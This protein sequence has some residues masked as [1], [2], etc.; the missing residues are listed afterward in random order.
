MRIRFLLPVLLGSLFGVTL[1][2]QPLSNQVLQLLTRVNTWTATNTFLDLRLTTGV[3]SD[4][5]LRFYVDNS[6]NLYF[7][8]VL[9]AG[10]GSGVTPHNVLSTTHPDTLTGTVVR[11]DVIV[12]NATPK[13]A[14]LAKG[15]AGQFLRSDGTDVSW[16]V[17][18]SALTN[19]N[20]AALTGTLGAASGVNLTNLNASN[21]ASGT[22]PLARLSGITNTQIDA[23][24]AI[25]YAKLNLTGAVLNADIAAAA[26]IPYSKLTLTNSL[27][28]AD[29][30]NATLTFGK[31][32]ANGCTNGQVPQYNGAAWVCG[33]LGAGTGTVTSV[34]LALPA[35]FSVSG[36]PVTTSGTLT[37]TLAT[38]TANTVFAGPTTGAAATP[39][40]RA[41]VNAD[42][43][44]TG[45]VAG[46]Y[47][48][49][50]TVNTA[51]VVT[52][53]TAALN[54]AA[55]VGASIL[56]R[57]NGGTGVA[58][59]ADDT[60]LVGSGA[61]WVAQTLSNC[62]AG[63][64]YL[65]ASNTF[66]CV[67]TIVA[68]NLLSASHA[69]TVAASPVR[70]DLLVGNST[71]AWTKIAVGTAGQ[72]LTN[73]AVDP[74]W[75]N[76]LAR[77]T[78]T[79]SQPWTFTQTWNDGAVTF[80]AFLVNIT[81]TASAA[82]SKLLDLQVASVSKFSVDKSGNVAAAGTLA[83]TGTST[84]TGAVTLTAAPAQVA[85]LTTAGN[86]LPVL[87]AT[88]GLLAGQ[89]ANIAVT[90]LLAS[91]PVGFYRVCAF[92]A[93]TT[94]AS[95]SS[96]MPRVTISFNNGVAQTFTLI[97]SNSGNTT[98]TFGQDCMVFHAAAAS[99]IA[100][101]AGTTG[102]AYASSGTAMQYHLRV[103]LEAL[104]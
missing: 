46:T 60:L 66:P 44:V 84:F 47:A 24:A 45:V 81:S 71:P 73:N 101:D 10:A 1:S 94:A 57:A 52:A 51:G 96:T 95:V 25:A 69:D 19:L 32:A 33:T 42:L 49:G 88:T 38:Q 76:T 43:P 102:G 9:V 14:R 27:V 29:L 64:A 93:V 2:S 39:T 55:S 4:T 103:T 61:A 30:T 68:H 92:E 20:A 22:V 86:G 5:A 70:G 97:A 80:S 83:V 48:G 50:V 67:T 34:A 77:G 59:S 18:G 75:S 82:A 85:G 3:P 104:Y 89:T 98:T 31:W 56:P 21:L 41:L 37:G 26:G 36:S 65:T 35:I 7:N 11:G 79:T 15:T 58:V 100:Y 53:G 16:G 54:L 13:W 12:G 40:F 63:I 62:P 23:S 90:N 78:I 74:S 87:L 8:G 28:N 91:A 17:D 72:L 6:D 99:A